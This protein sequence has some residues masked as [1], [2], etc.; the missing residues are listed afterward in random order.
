MCVC[1]DKCNVD[2]ARFLGFSSC[3]CDV[4]D[5]DMLCHLDAMPM[6]CLKFRQMVRACCNMFQCVAVCFARALL[7]MSID[8]SNTHY[9]TPYNTPY[10]TQ[11]Q[12]MVRSGCL[13]SCLS[14]T[15]CTYCVCP[16]ERRRSAPSVRCVLLDSHVDWH[17]TFDVLSDLAAHH[18]DGS[19]S[20]HVRQ[21][22]AIT[23]LRQT[24][25]SLPP[26]LARAWLW[27]RDGRHCA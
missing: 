3:R 10:N 8:G 13:C 16:R 23:F 4:D 11:C 15:D 26:F 25:V 1:G 2:V 6:L 14:A 12:Q 19:G 21:S 27:R 22:K 5:V 20:A 7:K 18:V 24:K 9:N 17:C